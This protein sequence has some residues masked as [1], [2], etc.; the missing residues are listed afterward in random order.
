[1]A[2]V[3]EEV[4]AEAALVVVTLEA[5]A[6]MESASAE[7]ASQVEFRTLVAEDSAPLHL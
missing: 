1:M 3:E 2:G 5:A 6:E 7:R 4:T